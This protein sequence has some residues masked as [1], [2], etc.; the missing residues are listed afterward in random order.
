[1]ET[2]T[3]NQQEYNIA[4]PHDTGEHKNG[5]YLAHTD[6]EMICGAQQQINE[7]RNEYDTKS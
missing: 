3:E 2:Q 5:L 7:A 1:M 4:K 6:Q